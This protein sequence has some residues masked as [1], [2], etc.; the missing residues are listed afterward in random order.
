MLV[1]SSKYN[2]EQADFADWMFFQ[3]SNL[4]E[5]IKPHHK[6]SAQILLVLS[7]KDLNQHG[8]AEKKKILF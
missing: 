1:L 8:I 5:E 2:I 3:P 7:T 6:P 4:I